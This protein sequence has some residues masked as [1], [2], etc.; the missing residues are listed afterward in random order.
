M[1]EGTQPDVVHITTPPQSHFDVT[2]ICLEAGCHAYVEKPF[3]LNATEA[4]ELLTLAKKKGLKITVGHDAQF[5]PVALRMRKLVREGFLGGPPVHM[6]SLFCYDFG[7]QRYVKAFLGDET[8]WLRKLPG[9]LLQNI[10]SHGISKIAEFMTSDNPKV[11]ACGFNSPLIKNL[12]ET[13]II[14]ELRTIIYDDDTTAYFTF[15]SQFNPIPHQF[16]LYGKK[17]SLLVD[18]DNQTLIKFKGGKY[19]SYL[20]HFIPPFIQAKQ[21]TSNFLYNMNKFLKNDFHMDY[22]MRYLIKA[23]HRSI[24]DNEPLPM[25][26][27]E[28]LT[29]AR[30]MDSVFEQIKIPARSEH[31]FSDTCQY[32]QE[33]VSTPE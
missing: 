7:D 10:I 27:K 8:H 33:N 19:K 9:K 32:L 1:L 31:P 14:D 5:T 22:G 18:D 3:T 2:R 21:Y 15:S 20:N 25:T 24:S 13:D 23:F 17:N 16:R 26:Y 11:I 28:I 29:T 6:E 12:N 4:E 30:I